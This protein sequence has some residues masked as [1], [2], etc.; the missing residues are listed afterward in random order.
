MSWSDALAAA[1][2][3]QGRIRGGVPKKKKHALR[4][5]RLHGQAQVQ[6]RIIILRKAN[7][8]KVKLYDEAI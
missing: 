7:S 8:R 3:E 4:K 5:R 1:R 2:A 6:K